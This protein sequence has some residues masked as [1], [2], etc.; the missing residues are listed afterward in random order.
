MIGF[1]SSSTWSGL[2][3]AWTLCGSGLLLPAACQS[4]IGENNASVEI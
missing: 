4:I 3:P 1:L 2:P